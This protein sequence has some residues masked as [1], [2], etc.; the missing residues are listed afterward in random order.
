[1]SAFTDVKTELGVI[2]TTTNEIATDIDE[3]IAKLT[4]PGGMSEAE[5]AEVVTELR[6]VSTTLKG[7]A[8][9]YPAVPPVEP[10]V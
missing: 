4:Q 1:M 7:V 6:A 2:N 5:A 8:S 3:L 10:P 9:K